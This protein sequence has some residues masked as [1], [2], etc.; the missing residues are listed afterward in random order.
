MNSAQITKP[1]QLA[2]V[3]AMR[4][5]ER[6]GLTAREL[7][8]LFGDGFGGMGCDGT[9]ASAMIAQHLAKLEEEGLV[10]SEKKGKERSAPKAWTWVGPKPAA[11][12]EPPAQAEAD[13]LPAEVIDAM[14]DG[15]ITP[16][17]MAPYT[18]VLSHHNPLDA[19]LIAVREAALSMA[20]KPIDRREEKVACLS[21]LADI[22][23]PDIASLLNEIAEDI[24]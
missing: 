22:T 3:V 1:Y 14:R 8:R 2:R 12:V 17:K 11:D 4:I 23:A 18:V 15:M 5:A 20:R 24:Q 16:E 21:K 13:E 7:Y 10:I 19:A 9:S 6:P